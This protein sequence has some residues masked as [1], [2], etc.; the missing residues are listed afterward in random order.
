[1]PSGKPA[2]DFNQ[3]GLTISTPG[4]VTNAPTRTVLASRIIP[5]GAKAFLEIWAARVVDIG[6]DNQIYF[7]IERNGQAIQAGAQRIPG[8][9]FT[10]QPQ[11]ALNAYL[12][13]GLLEI[14]AYNISGVPVTIE[15]D[16][17]AA[18]A[19]KCQAWWT[20]TLLSE[21]GGIA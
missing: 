17:I 11:I 6:N 19:I 4:S 12:P 2:G 8:Q 15:P 5:A 18:V 10:Y 21:R 7:A 3:T 14:V 13:P 9:Q 20:G 1:M 16:A